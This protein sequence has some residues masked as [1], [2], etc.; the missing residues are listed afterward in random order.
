MMNDKFA[1]INHTWSF[2]IGIFLIVEL[3]VKVHFK[4]LCANFKV[5][6]FV[7]ICVVLFL[8]FQWLKWL[9]N[10]LVSLGI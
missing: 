6:K 1:I 5:Q 4:T 10:M 3:F 7:R 2:R 9:S 8:D